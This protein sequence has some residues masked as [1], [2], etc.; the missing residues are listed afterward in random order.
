M[1]VNNAF[2]NGSLADEVY[3]RQL[4]GFEVADANGNLLACKLNKALYG[5][6]QAP[7]AWFKKLHD[8]LV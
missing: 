6:K 4:P 5:L 7:R 1:D 2:L 3:M 8:F